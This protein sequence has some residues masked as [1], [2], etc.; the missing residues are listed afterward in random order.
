MR[1]RRSRWRAPRV[2]P[3]ASEAELCAVLRSA[4]E[5]AGWAF[6]PETGGW[7]AILVLEDETQVGVQAK[8]R[9]NVDVLA[10]AIVPPRLAGPDIHAVLV[11]SCSRAFQDVAHE[12]GF[13]VLIGDRLRRKPDPD[14]R[15]V[16]AYVGERYLEHSVRKAPRAI[17]LPGRCWLP[18]FVPNSPAGVPSPRS[19]TPWRVAA[20]KLCAELRK[21]Y[22]PTNAE[23]RERGL[24][25]STWVR[26]WIE[27]VAGTRPRRYRLIPG[28]TLPDV[29]FPDISRQLGLPEPTRA[30]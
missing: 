15:G 4:A 27:P 30:A 17:H 22:E 20:A 14:I 12:L 11:P 18:P 19:V 5:A 13:I 21:G 29:A 8:L 23:L 28:V 16:G 10:Q 25:P 2:V 26:R 6:Y 7:D 24:A 3:F 9:A 1:S